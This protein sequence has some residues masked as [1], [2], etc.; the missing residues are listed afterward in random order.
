MALF[1]FVASVRSTPHSVASDDMHRTSAVDDLVVLL[2]AKARDFVDS[3]LVARI[4][5]TEY[6]V[7]SNYLGSLMLY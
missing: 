2:R 3:S 5:S 7:W 6:S 1:V 4:Q